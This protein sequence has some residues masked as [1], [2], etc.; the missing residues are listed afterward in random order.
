LACELVFC[1][2]AITSRFSG[3]L[4]PP[5]TQ[6]PPAIGR[7]L[8][9][10]AFPELGAVKGAVLVEERLCLPGLHLVANERCA[11][12]LSDCANAPNLW[13]L[14]HTGRSWTSVWASGTL[15]DS[16]IHV[17]AAPGPG[18]GASLLFCTSYQLSWKCRRDRSLRF[19][20][21]RCWQLPPAA[22]SSLRSTTS[23]DLSGPTG[24]IPPRSSTCSGA[25][26]ITSQPVE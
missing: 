12:S 1:Q 15:V 13:A 3:P 21:R 17:T 16:R 23:S 4:S 6:R 10:I 14:S 9:E 25:D 24:S 20:H 22:T 2:N 7:L 26:A 11:N 5:P 18:L 19:P 8:A